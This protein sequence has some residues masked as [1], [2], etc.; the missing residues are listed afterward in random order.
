MR[1]RL[2]FLRSASFERNIC[3]TGNGDENHAELMLSALV[4]LLR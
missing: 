3:L 1:S 4:G 2:N